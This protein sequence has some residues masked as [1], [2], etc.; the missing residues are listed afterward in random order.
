MQDMDELDELIANAP[1]EFFDVVPTPAT[2]EPRKRPHQDPRT[3]ELSG[4][5]TSEGDE[6]P[7]VYTSKPSTPLALKHPTMSAALPRATPDSTETTDPNALL[8]R[9]LN[10]TNEERAK[11]VPVVLDQ[12]QEAALQAIMDGKN[13]V[14]I[15]PPG[16]GKSVLLR[17]ADA[18]LTEAGR[19]VNCVAHN[20]VAA[21]NINGMTIHSFFGLGK[22]LFPPFNAKSAHKDVKER[23]IGTGILGAIVSALIVAPAFMGKTMALGALVVAFS[24]S[25]L[26]GSVM[27]LFALKLLERAGFAERQGDQK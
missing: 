13:I 21:A 1:A 20:G 3:D 25:T 24:G 26:A 15:G 12:Q 9:L 22:Q 19:V 11:A 18:R 2:V 14:I 10:R 4:G 17:E 8:I 5:D 7:Q 6:V 16:S 27:G 23:V